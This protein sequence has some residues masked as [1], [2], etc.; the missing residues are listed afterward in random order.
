MRKA[1]ITRGTS[2]TE[3]VV[4]INLD[5]TG[6]TSFSTGL[7]FL[8]HML[9]Q[10]GRHGLID[11]DIKAKGDLHIDNHHTIEDIGITL[12]E[13]QF[14][15]PMSDMPLSGDKLTFD[16]LNIQFIVDEELRNYRELWEWIVGIGF[17][18]NHSQFSNV[19]SQS[20]LNVN[21]PGATRQTLQSAPPDGGPRDNPAYSETPIYTDATMVFY[22]SKNIAKV[23]ISYK[24]LFPTSLGGIDLM[25]DSGDVE[26]IRVDA[27]FRFMYYE[28]ATST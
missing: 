18:K 22:N 3:V 19:L 4:K 14:P 16:T 1:E 9:D 6:E 13:A 5:G 10:I 28:F 15:T 21:L 25:V 12:G 26:Y 2:E 17:P 8:E 27:S 24:D 7:P 20:K 11:L 23:E